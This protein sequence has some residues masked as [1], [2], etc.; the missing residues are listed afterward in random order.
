MVHMLSFHFR[1]Y[2]VIKIMV[3]K[4]YFIFIYLFIQESSHSTGETTG[5]F[6]SL[7]SKYSHSNKPNIVQRLIF[8]YSQSGQ[9][10]AN[11]HSLDLMSRKILLGPIN[12]ERYLFLI[13]VLCLFQLRN[14]TYRSQHKFMFC[15]LLHAY[16]QKQQ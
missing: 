9:E 13:M 1:K 14:I 11:I 4:V 8:Q 12:P 15:S 3:S 7:N 10:Y 5:A 2:Y 6:L 16:T